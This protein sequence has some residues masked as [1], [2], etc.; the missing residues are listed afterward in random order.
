MDNKDGEKGHICRFRV[1]F[2]LVIMAFS[3]LFLSSNAKALILD[4]ILQ[5]F[6]FNNN[7]IDSSG[8]YNGTNSSVIFTP[9]GLIKQALNLTGISGKSVN[10]S[11]NIRKNTNDNYTINFWVKFTTS[12]RTMV[13][14]TQ[15]DDDN[16]M[17]IEFNWNKGNNIPSV[18]MDLI[19]SD[20]YSGYCD[21]DELL[22]ANYSTLNNGSYHMITY[23]FDKSSTIGLIYIDGILQKNSSIT[24][25][26]FPTTISWIGQSRDYVYSPFNGSLDEFSIWNR[27]LDYNEVSQLYETGRGI[28][29]PFSYAG[30]FSI[31]A[32]DLYNQSINI[33]SFS[34]LINGTIYNTTTGLIITDINASLSRIYNITILSN[35]NG[36]YFNKTYL[37]YTTNTNLTAYMYQAEANATI[38]MKI[39]NISVPLNVNTNIT[40]FTNPNQSTNNYTDR[41]Y[42]RANQNI[43]FRASGGYGYFIYTTVNLPPLFNGSIDLMGLYNQTLLV[44]LRDGNNN[45]V[46]NNY[47]LIISNTSYNYTETFT[48]SNGNIT[49]GIL[50]NY[51][52]NITF[53][54]LFTNYS[55]LSTN[56]TTIDNSTNFRRFFTFTSNSINISIY[57]ETDK[58][59]INER[60]NIELKSDYLILNYNTSN[61]KRYIDNIPEGFYN[62]KFTAP[63]N[64]FSERIY[65]ISVFNRTNQL[66][67]VYMPMLNGSASISIYLKTI[68]NNILENGLITIQ[69]QFNTTWLTIAQKYTDVTGLAVFNLVNAETYKF[70]IS[71]EGYTTREFELQ[72]YYVNSPYNIKLEPTGYTPY[73]NAYQ[74]VQYYYNPTSSIVTPQSA[75]NFSI[76]TFSNESKM[77]YTYINVNGSILN[78]TGSPSGATAML[79]YNLTNYQGTIPVT[80]G[81]KVQGFNPILWTINYYVNQNQGYSD[82]NIYTTLTAVK[83]EVNNQGWTTLI[84]IFVAIVVAITITQLSGNPTISTIGAFVVLIFFLLIGWLPLTAVAFA[85]IIGLL[86]LYLQRGGY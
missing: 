12:I 63:S 37:N 56:F 18:C 69:K 58:T 11:A 52:F 32:V 78:L 49:I 45:A 15:I 65:Y 3:V 64:N 13:Y 29:Y 50:R 60:I 7:F 70:I 81:F 55:I 72:V 8:H 54:P 20:V 75:V 61:G 51:D 43:T 34:A 77:E 85:S 39:L 19:V 62:A 84:A 73:T 25:Q 71:A 57:N 68:D 2:I 28:E 82:T 31:K 44:Q 22:G 33:S 4:N 10:L 80:Y 48:T 1:A 36:G 76:T 27:S 86:M 42:L 17:Q 9:N 35:E 59:Y 14:G 41:F 21:Y 16:F 47:T 40:I 66:L 30:F 38:Y 5:N 26:Q 23:V 67:N 74:Y 6:A 79:S 46:I 53:I 83:T 24:P